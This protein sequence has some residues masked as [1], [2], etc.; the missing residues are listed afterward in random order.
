[1]GKIKRSTP[2]ATLNRYMVFGN[3]DKIFELS[4]TFRDSQSYDAGPE[5]TIPGML[6]TT[7]CPV[8]PEPG[9]L[10]NSRLPVISADLSK[11]DLIDPATLVMKV[12]GFGE[13]PA[14]FDSTTSTISWQVNRRLRQASCQVAVSWKDLTT[15]KPT[16][17]PLRWSFLIDHVATY[18]PDAK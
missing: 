9:T 16:E 8:S 6:P 10:I 13:V 5:G 18:L 11:I 15:G 14:R 12:S 17:S 7:P 4:T 3:Y 1:P 2:D